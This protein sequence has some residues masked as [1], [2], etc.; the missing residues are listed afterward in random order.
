MKKLFIIGLSVFAVMA[1]N[2]VDDTELNLN[3][4]HKGELYGAGDEDISEENMIIEKEH[5]WEDLL[6][7]IDA[8]NNESE[9][10]TETKIDFKEFI[11]IACFDKVRPSSGYS[12]EITNTEIKSKEVVFTLTKGS[13]EGMA[14]TVITQPYYL[15]KFPKT[16]KEITFTE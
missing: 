3:L 16:N 12:V 13:P 5:E 7:K 15:A 4:I 2:K 8:V 10:F 11:V 6:E 9:N 14:A 1:C